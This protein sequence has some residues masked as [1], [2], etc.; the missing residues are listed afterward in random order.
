[1]LQ[2]SRGTPPYGKVARCTVWRRS[3]PERARE[4]RR[5]YYGEQTYK[6]RTWT[7]QEIQIVLAREASD[8]ELA[9]CLGRSVMAIQITR[10]RTKRRAAQR[11]ARMQDTARALRLLPWPRREA[12]PLDQQP[13]ERER[14]V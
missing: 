11:L 12:S 8:H 10:H 13:T 9:R 1:M 5:R 4:H 14:D 7:S 2:K 6:R 3:H